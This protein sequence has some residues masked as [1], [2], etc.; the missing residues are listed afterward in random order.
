VERRLAAIL[1][2]DVEGYSRLMGADEVG[3]LRDLTQ[4]RA[5]LD[6]L[7]ASH[8]GRIANTGGDSVL[9]EFGSAVDAVQCAVEAQAALAIANEGLSPERHMNFRIGIHVGDV[10]VK[11]GDLFGD[12]VNIAARLQTIASAG[13]TCISGVAHDQV[14]KILPFAFTDLGAQQVKN[15]E[16]PVRAF[17]VSAKDASVAAG[18]LNASMPLALPDKPSIAVLPFQNMS[19]DPEQE[20]FADGMVEDIITALSRFKSLFVI[21]RNSSFTYKG[22]PVD[23]KQAGRELGVRYVLEGSVRKAAGR[24]RITGQLIDCETGSH[25]WADRFDGSL[26]DVFQLQDDVTTSVVGAITPKIERAE[27]ERT[28]R[29]PFDSLTAY[30]LLLRGISCTH[31]DTRDSW[32][33]ALRLFNRAIEID[34]SASAPLGKAAT[35][36]NIRKIHGWIADQEAEEAETRRLASRVKV[37]GLDDAAALC[38]A[39]FALFRVCR[40]Y[41]AGTAMV[42]RALSLNQNLADVWHFRGLVSLFSGQHEAAVEQ[43]S[44]SLRMNPLSPLVYRDEAIIGQALLLL[45]RYDESLKMTAR[46]LSRNANWTPALRASAAA[47]ALAG[48]VSEAQKVVARLRHLNPTLT[49]SD[50]KYVLTYKEPHDI[51]LYV[52]GLRLAGLPE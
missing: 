21:A 30:D 39:G 1:A 35:C 18:L 8:R 31:V 43:I 32:E 17:A 52:D 36:Y 27:I 33:E 42:D 7:I 38:S 9:A 2:A 23:I 50:L 20:Y 46:S 3:T 26:Q 41:D 16:E 29:K 51:A 13:G 10:M 22:K 25:L 15:I 49:L 24:V 45:G 44:C 14:R 12:G 28:L 47:H 34:P 5:I 37:I 11:G 4:R 19:G 6:G 40:E 48:N